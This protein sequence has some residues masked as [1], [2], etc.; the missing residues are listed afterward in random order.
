MRL[1]LRPTLFGHWKNH[2]EFVKYDEVK[3]KESKK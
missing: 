2:H 3:Q 1:N